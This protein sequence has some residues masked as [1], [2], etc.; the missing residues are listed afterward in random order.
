MI[1][2]APAL[3]KA[4]DRGQKKSGGTKTRRRQTQ[5]RASF[6]RARQVVRNVVERRIQL[7]ADALHGTDRGDRDE[8]GDEAVFDGR[9]ALF[10]LK[11]LQ[12]LGHL[13]VSRMARATKN[14][15]DLR[16][17]TRVGWSGI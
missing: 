2:N 7:V 12:K 8:S 17:R 16:K 10:V 9:R 4:K 13:L 6:L 15:P 3:S 1:V 5:T 14:D 11:K